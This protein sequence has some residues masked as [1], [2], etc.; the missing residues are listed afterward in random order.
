MIITLIT[1]LILNL[2]I[3]QISSRSKKSINTSTQSSLTSYKPKFLIEE[4]KP[5]STNFHIAMEYLSSYPYQISYE[6]YLSEINLETFYSNEYLFEDYLHTFEE[7]QNQIQTNESLWNTFELYYK[8]NNRIIKINNLNKNSKF[9]VKYRILSSNYSSLYSDIKIITLQHLENKVNIYLKGTGKNNHDN[10]E[11]YLNN[12]NIFKH[13]K[14]QGLACI[15]LNRKNLSI[16]DIK[17][18]N[19]YQ[20]N[21][22][23]IKYTDNFTKFEVD[24]SNNETISN[25]TTQKTIN[26]TNILI[27]SENLIKFL[28]KLKTNQILIIL[29][30]YGWEKYFTYEVAETLTKFGAIKIK[31][32]ASSFY[33]KN[34][35][36]SHKEK[37]I[38]G[39]N[40]YFHPYAFLGIKNIGQ[41]NGYEVIQTNKGHYLTTEGLIPAEIIVSMKY[42]KNNMAY[43]FDMNQKYQYNLINHNYLFESLDFSLNNLFIL[44][45]FKNQT[46]TYN[47]HFSIYNENKDDITYLNKSELENGI[48]QTELDKVVFGE[49]IQSVKTDYNGNIYQ[50]GTC[51]KELKYYNF[52][53]SNIKGINCLPPYTP[54]GNECISPNLI[55]EYKYN[56]SLIMCGIGVQPQICKNNQEFINES[57]KGFE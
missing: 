13:G 54:N 28:N 1:I 19:T 18:F 37:N 39:K 17:Y 15:I 32:L 8:G 3:N 7:I 33:F 57:F 31:E 38:L 44:L 48:Y 52:Y 35:E 42:D 16:M 55:D 20:K 4:I 24:S 21:N 22:T 12:I 50:N 46:S 14:F 10:A 40:K 51:I 2:I 49:N 11:V 27:E 6:V 5:S 26:K 56:I 25:T 9:R 23:I 34:N 43:F 47:F 29:S 53:E 36:D 45:F 30:C 41:G